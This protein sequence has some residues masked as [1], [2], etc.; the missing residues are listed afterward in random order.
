MPYIL[1][2]GLLEAEKSL[3]FKVSVKGSIGISLGS[4]ES[5]EDDS[6]RLLV[7]SIEAGL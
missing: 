2:L 4:D 3:G 5:G 1:F 6:Q 7:F